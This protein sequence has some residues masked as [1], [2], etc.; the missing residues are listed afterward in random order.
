MPYGEL[1]IKIPSVSPQCRCVQVECINERE[2]M[3]CEQV[4][5]LCRG[6]ESEGHYG[7]SDLDGGKWK[8]LLSNVDAV[9]IHWHYRAKPK[10]QLVVPWELIP[11]EYICVT[12]NKNSKVFISKHTDGV[13]LFFPLKLDLEGVELPVTVHRPTENGDK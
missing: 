4:L 7:L 6:E 12:V 1:L 9:N 2:Q 13:Y 3:L 8:P 5:R 10:K 11:D